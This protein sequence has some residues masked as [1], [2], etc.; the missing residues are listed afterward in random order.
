MKEVFSP[1]EGEPHLDGDD[2]ADIAEDDEADNGSI[3]EMLGLYGSA[4]NP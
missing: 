3:R 2:R 4:W 1:Y